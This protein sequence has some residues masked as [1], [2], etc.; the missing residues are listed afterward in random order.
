MLDWQILGDESN[1]VNFSGS[2]EVFGKTYLEQLVW[3]YSQYSKRLNVILAQ[4]N[5]ALLEKLNKQYK[6]LGIDSSSNDTASALILDSRFAIIAIDRLVGDAQLFESDEVAN[7]YYYKKEV[8]AILLTATLRQKLSQQDVATYNNTSLSALEH[9]LLHLAPN[10]NL[11]KLKKKQVIR[12]KK[13]AGMRRFMTLINRVKQRQLMK[14]GVLIIDKKSTWIEP[15]V[16]IGVGTLVYP[17]ALLRGSTV[18]GR[19][20]QIGPAARIDDSR[21]GEAVTVKDSTVLSSSIDNHTTVGPYAYIRPNSEIGKNVKIGDFVEVKNARIGDE[22]KV[23]HLSYIG[24][25]VVGKNVNIGCGAVFVN[26]DGYN[27][28]KTVVEDNCFI[29][30]NVNLIAPVTVNNGAYVAAGSTITNDVASDSLA[31]ARARQSAKP[32]WAKKWAQLKKKAK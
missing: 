13:M 26:Y 1:E 31:I 9:L 6:C 4:P 19:N 2:F 32:N 12:I 15:D 10:S 14:S 17:G 24:D 29:G 21:I 23:S 20:C 18:I 8:V 30:C 25:G 22:S 7:I 27:K 11:I 28:H 3:Y 16:Q 5:Q